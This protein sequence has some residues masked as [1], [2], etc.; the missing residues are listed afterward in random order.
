M[1]KEPADIRILLEAALAADDAVAV[2]GVKEWLRNSR[3]EDVELQRI[4]A[5]R[6]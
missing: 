3:L 4:T 5:P 2:D 6:G 1:Q